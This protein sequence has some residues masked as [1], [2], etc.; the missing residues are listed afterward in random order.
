METYTVK[1]KR[2]VTDEQPQHVCDICQEPAT[3]A[4]T[5]ALEMTPGVWEQSGR[6]YGCS[7]HPVKSKTKYLE[8]DIDHA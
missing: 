2:T 5:D 7:L 1:D 4:C 8:G 3:C 6:R